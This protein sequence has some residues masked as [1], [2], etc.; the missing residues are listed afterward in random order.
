MEDKDNFQTAEA[1][2]RLFCELNAGIRSAEEDG[3]VSEE[4]MRAY[5]R[6]MRNE[7]QL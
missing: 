5:L 3:W 4:E 2:I 1:M 6:N 7:A